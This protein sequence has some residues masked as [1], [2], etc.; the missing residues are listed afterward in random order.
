MLR[1]S[2][3]LICILT[4]CTTFGQ[5]KVN[6]LSDG[7][8]TISLRV[9]AYG[10]NAK[11]ATESAGQS[12]IQ[13]I[14]FRGIPDSNQAG[15]PLIGVDEE[16]IEKEHKKYFKEFFD[17][18][19]CNSFV[20]SNIPVSKFAKDVTKKKCIVVDVKVNLQALRSDLECH[21]VIRKFGF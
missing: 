17:E 11:E 13:A 9:T 14:L 15:K 19:R 6:F 20:L 7:T 1:H 10:K 5:D 4:A 18:N 12:A 16:K 21:K 3:F 2:L 8:N